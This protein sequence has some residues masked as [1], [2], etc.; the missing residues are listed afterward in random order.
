MIAEITYDLIMDDDMPFVEG[1]YR[2]AGH[3]WEVFIISKWRVNSTKYHCGKWDSGVTG[4]SIKVPW[5]MSLSMETVEL[6][7]SAKLDVNA[8]RTVRGPDS[9]VIR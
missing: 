4:Y 3:D 6:V 8:W 5:Y 7:L 1:C 9:I 2:L